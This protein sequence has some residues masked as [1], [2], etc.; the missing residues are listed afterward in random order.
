VTLT[1]PLPA[2]YNAPHPATEASTIGGGWWKIRYTFTAATSDT[3]TWMVSIRGNP[4]HLV[5]P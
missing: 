5:Q 3:T 4:V 1:V 2:T